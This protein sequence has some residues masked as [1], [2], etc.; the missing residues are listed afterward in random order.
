M[1]LSLLALPLLCLGTAAFATP[2][3]TTSPNGVLP[4]GVT[5]VGGIVVDLQGANGTRVVSQLAA[6]QL[7]RGY[8]NGSENP[9]PGVAEGNPLLF[10]TQTGFT[11]AIIAALGGGISAMSVRITLFDGDS[12]N[13]DFD[14]NDNTFFVNGVNLGNW[15]GVTTYQTSGD[16]LTLLST[17]AGFG[18]DILSTGFFSTSNAA[19]LASIFSSLSSTNAFAFTLNDIDPNDNFYDFTQGV[20]G[21]LINVGTGPVVQPPSGAVPEPATWAMMLTGF[22]AIGTMLRRP[23]S[24]RRRRLAVAAA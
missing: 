12:A 6:S 21:G 16:G 18:D 4:A 7:Y 19:T 3:T 9:V 1:K 20:D 2:E 10:G 24:T 14:F 23:A 5:Q 15:S 11:S 13:G 8:A 17:G 22:G